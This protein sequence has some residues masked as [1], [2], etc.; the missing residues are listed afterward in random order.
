[1]SDRLPIKI[2]KRMQKG[3]TGNWGHPNKFEKQHTNVKLALEDTIIHIPAKRKRH[4][5][6]KYSFFRDICPF[7]KTELP[8][9]EKEEEKQ[10]RE[11]VFFRL[12]R[13]RVKICPNCGAFEVLECPSCKRKTWL[14][15]KTHIYKHQGNECGFIGKKKD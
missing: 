8:I 15:I 7:C 13:V 3:A 5:K 10:R 4:I 9:D 11:G 14:D 6:R 2:T 1:M 12:F